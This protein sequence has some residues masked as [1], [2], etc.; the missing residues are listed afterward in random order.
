MLQD[1]ETDVWSL[2]KPSTVL[3]C[4]Q[5]P[6]IVIQTPKKQLDMD[7]NL[8]DTIFLLFLGFQNV[9]RLKTNLGH[10]FTVDVSQGYGAVAHG[11]GEGL[12]QAAPQLGCH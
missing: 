9:L 3:R 8:Q 10:G 1:A 2:S 7:Q 6:T 5:I 12:C 11:A 4:T